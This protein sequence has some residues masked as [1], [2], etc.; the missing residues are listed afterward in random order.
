MSPHRRA[1][2]NTC[3]LTPSAAPQP[4]PQSRQQ[5]VRQPPVVP[6]TKRGDS[7]ASPSPHSLSPSLS[8]PPSRACELS[9]GHKRPPAALAL[10]APDVTQ[11]PASQPASQCS[12]RRGWTAPPAIGPKGFLLALR[13]AGCAV[14]RR[15]RRPGVA[16]PASD[17]RS[18][19]G[20]QPRW[21]RRWW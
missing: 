11:R 10:A 15:W 17:G 21:W 16:L 4:R 2:P 13:D 14:G 3:V 19:V 6:F 7:Q 5:R 1:R 9:Q 8:L 18:G 20:R 12:S